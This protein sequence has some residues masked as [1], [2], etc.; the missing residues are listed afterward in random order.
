MK[1]SIYAFLVITIKAQDDDKGIKW[2]GDCSADPT[3]CI[4]T[5]ECCGPLVDENARNNQHTLCI[6]EWY[7]TRLK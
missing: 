6:E 2:D 7:T 4:Y 1:F 5:A 3:N